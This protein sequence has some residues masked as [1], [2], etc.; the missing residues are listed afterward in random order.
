MT[1]L[2]P[3][4]TLRCRPFL[5]GWLAVVFFSGCSPWQAASSDRSGLIADWL[6]GNSAL[7]AARSSLF[8]QRP[9]LE[10]LW[11]PDLAILP[12]ADISDDRITIH[13]IRWCRYRTEDNYDTRHY[14]IEFPL[15]DVVQVDFLIVP[16]KGNPLLAHTMLSFGLRD[17]RHFVISVEARLEQ[18]ETYSTVAGPNKRFELMYLIADERDIIPLR[19]EVRQVDVYLY[20][21]RASPQQ[22]QALLVDMLQRTNKLARDPEFY[23]LVRNN[24]TTNLVKHINQLRPGAIPADWRV[25]LPGH[26]DALAYELGLLDIP[27][28]FAVAKASSKINGLVHLHRDDPNF[29][30]RIRRQ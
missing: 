30:R 6:A 24:C 11:R 15:A 20:P 5:Q 10:R 7:D 13:N 16:F 8:R 21:G 9:T 1:A 4:S 27:T 23:D 14:D 19:T 26:S 25:L 3:S 17:G 22:V 12:Y 2:L 18:G 29:S 28:S